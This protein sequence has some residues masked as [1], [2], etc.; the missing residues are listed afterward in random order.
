MAVGFEHNGL[1]ATSIVR[2]EVEAWPLI[3]PLLIVLKTYLSKLGL[4]LTYTGGLCSHALF[5]LVRAYV[6]AITSDALKNDRAPPTNLGSSLVG[7]LRW[8]GDFDF[9]RVQV[10]WST[11]M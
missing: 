6:V 11:S 10:C 3:R 4:N 1:A 7:L 5:L 2:T 9:S 8:Y